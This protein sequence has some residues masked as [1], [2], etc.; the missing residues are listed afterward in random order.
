MLIRTYP[1]NAVFW[2]LLLILSAVPASGQDARAAFR[3]MEY[4]VENLFDSDH[5]SLKMDTQ[6]TPD[7]EYHWTH[8]RYWRKLNAVSR[9][10]V[11]SS[12]DNSTL[13]LPDVIGL[14]EVENDSV[15]TA[16]TCRSLLRGARYEYVMTS[17]PDVRGIDVALLYQPMTFRLAAHHSLRID[18]LPGMRPTRDILYVKGET[19]YGDLHIY[20]LHAPSR[21]GGA[22]KTRPYRMA[23]ARRLVASVDSLCRVSPSPRVIVMGDFNDYSDDEALCILSAAGLVE[24]TSSGRISPTPGVRGTYRYQ[25]VWGSLDHIFVSSALLPFF[26]RSY[27]AAPPEL[28]EDDT[29]YGGVRPFR[30][31]RGPI[32]NGGYSDHLPL[33]A[34]FSF[35]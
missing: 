1:A 16:L 28:L 2:L 22:R 25:G 6:F 32:Y 30:H 11:L 7:G 10:I 14:C 4:N 23:V 24:V 21:S 9:A 26:S 29:K 13:H 18:P 35:R 15:L 34:D 33:I 27:I 8:G 12:T 5:D 19:L 20:V 31:F 3:V 17:S